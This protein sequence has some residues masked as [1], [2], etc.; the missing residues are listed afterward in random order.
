MRKRSKKYLF[1]L[2]PVLD[3][4]V[5]KMEVPA[6]IKDDP[7]QFLHA[8]E[9]AEEINVAGFFAATMAWGKR[10]IVIAKVDDLLS[11]MAYRPLDFIGNFTESDA[12]RLTGFKHRTFN[13]E[14]MYWLIKT[15]QQILI[16]FTTFEAFW[17]N[18]L[19]L[20]TAKNRPLMGVFHEEFFSFFP[21][22]PAR[23]R[24]HISNPEKGGSCKRLYMYLRW[25][26]RGGPVDVGS[27]NF[28]PPSQIY[29]PLDVHVARQSRKL[30]LITRNQNDWKA[31][32]ELQEQL[33]LLDPLDPSKYDYALFGLGLHP[34]WLD[35]KW[36]LNH[37]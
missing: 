36:I 20:S 26:I 12:R 24:R 23:T 35:K 27:M 34:H 28:M 37:L 4:W 30:G 32:E 6:Y 18:C 11:R 31:V 9:D 13:S 17:A 21:E 5:S 29:I 15:M 22:I 16:Q 8:F 14:D 7:I 19:T 25:T 3:Q 1:Q 2:K 33:L 10:S